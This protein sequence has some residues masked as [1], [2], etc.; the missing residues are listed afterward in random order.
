[1]CGKESEYLSE[2]VR[3]VLRNFP[4]DFIHDNFAEIDPKKEYF[5]HCASGYRSLIAASI[6]KANGVE[7]VSDVRGGFKD[8]KETEA[9]MTDYVCPDQPYYNLDEIEIKR[10]LELPFFYVIL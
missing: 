3:G 7:K 4:L 9:P 8:L 10:E 6:F 1:M 2:H 5:L